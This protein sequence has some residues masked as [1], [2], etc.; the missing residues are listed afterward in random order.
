MPFAAAAGA[1]V[2]IAKFG[3]QIFGAAKAT[4]ARNALSKEQRGMADEYG[5]AKDEAW[6]DYSTPESLQAAT[7]DARREVGGK[8]SIQSYMEESADIGLNRHL[9][10]V[11]DFSTSGAQGLASVEGAI[12]AANEAKG[13]AAIAG[14]Q[15][16]SAKKATLRG[17]Q[18]EA[19]GYEDKAWE[20]NVNSKYLQNMQF[21]Q[22][23][24]G[25]AQGNKAAAADTLASLGS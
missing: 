24:I 19:A 20:M 11:R 22:D 17:L 6:E 13:A 12:R 18:S 16:T 3:A 14:Q 23:Y 1:A 10:G 25:A 4:K 7:D 8:S 9:Q 5:K 15:E 2:D 21:E